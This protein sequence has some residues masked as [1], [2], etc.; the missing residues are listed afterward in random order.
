VDRFFPV[1]FAEGLVPHHHHRRQGAAAE[2]G[3]RLEGVFHVRRGFTVL[4]A[5]PGLEG[6]R[7]ALGAADMAGGAVAD[8]DDLLPH[9][10]EAELGIEGRHPVQLGLGHLRGRGDPFHGFKGDVM[11]FLLDFSGPQSA[12]MLVHPGYNASQNRF[13]SY[14]SSQGLFEEIRPLINQ[15][16]VDKNGNPIAA[17]YENASQL[18]YGT[19]DSNSYNHWYFADSTLY[20]R[21][22]WGRLNFSDPSSLMVL[23][24]SNPAEEAGRDILG[25]QKT[26]GIIISA[27]YYDFDNQ[28]VID[29][30]SSDLYKWEQWELPAYSE[31]LKES[32]F[33][34]QEYFKNI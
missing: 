12:R 13:S 29:L 8:L 2:A 28:Q 23:N 26:D 19:F 5:E 14:A 24:D 21:L 15:A 20:I 25:T 10:G 27:L 9:R 11:E 31:R 30:L 16:R 18:N 4:D 7:Q 32:Y 3:H 1:Q 22:P 33:I 34:I 6:F 17:L